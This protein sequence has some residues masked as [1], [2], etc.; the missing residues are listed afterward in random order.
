MTLQAS[1]GSPRPPLRMNIVRVTVLVPAHFVHSSGVC[2]D[3]C[4]V[5]SSMVATA[6]SKSATPQQDPV[7]R[8]QHFGLS[9]SPPKRGARANHQL[10][11]DDGPATKP[12]PASRNFKPKGLAENFKRATKAA[13][14]KAP[15]ALP[16]ELGRG[17]DR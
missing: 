5:Y 4:G 3:S 9:R 10:E 15:A 13:S 14:K 6:A 12:A 16:E 11:A 8:D 17:R 2:L 7:D 1:V